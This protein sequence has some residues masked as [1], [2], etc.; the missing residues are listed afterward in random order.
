M[1]G[2]PSVSTSP[3]D[4][5]LV[6]PSRNEAPSIGPVLREWWSHRPAE[7]RYE[8]LV[9]DDASADG[10]PEVLRELSHEFPVRWIRNSTSLGF[11]GALRAG[12]LETKTDWVAF[13]DADGQYDPDD[14]PKLL[15]ATSGGSDLVV[16][17]RSPRVDPFARRALSIGFRG[18]LYAF[19]RCRSKDPTSSL[20]VGRT[21]KVRA[22]AQSVRYMNGSFWNEFMIRWVRAGNSFVEVRVRHRPRRGGQ[23]KVASRSQVLG[24]SVQQL[25]AL[26]R[27][28]REFHPR[29]ASDPTNPHL[30]DRKPPYPSGPG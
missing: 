2:S 9:V 28:W 21:Q 26:L 15:H 6:V 24:V 8:I 7:A 13:A 5:T 3:F 27:V 29:R 18:L 23:S 10:T 11:G 20:K 14:L 4:L 16:G 25:I 19:F 12:I 1:G 30:T 17:V 22:L